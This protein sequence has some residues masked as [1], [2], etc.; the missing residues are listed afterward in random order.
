MDRRKGAHATTL[1]LGM[2]NFRPVLNPCESVSIRGP[3]F[4]AD[5]RELATDG[6][7]FTRINMPQHRIAWIRANGSAV[8]LRNVY[9]RDGKAPG[10]QGT[11]RFLPFRWAFGLASSF[12]S[13]T[14]PCVTEVSVRH[15]RTKV[16][17]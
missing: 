16:D 5:K 1:N 11:L 12:V 2:G 7:G 9:G 10:V 13:H 6:H 3:S 17:T 14:L 8:A 15:N 4:L